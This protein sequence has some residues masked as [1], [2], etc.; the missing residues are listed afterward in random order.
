M[1]TRSSLQRGLELA[2]LGLREHAYL[3]G[4]GSPQFHEQLRHALGVVL[5]ES[6]RVSGLPP[7]VTP[8]TGIGVH[9]GLG[10]DDK[11]GG[12]KPGYRGEQEPH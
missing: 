8:T 9:R 7:L 1:V 11:P 2:P 3:F 6:Q 10:S 12:E 4:R 5:G